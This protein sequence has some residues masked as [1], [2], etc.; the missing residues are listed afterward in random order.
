MHK[1]VVISGYCTLDHAIREGTSFTPR[2]GGAVLYAG[3]PL[4]DAGHLVTP[5]ARIG[6]DTEAMRC[7]AEAEKDGLDIS[8]FVRDPTASMARCLMIYRDDDSC[9]CALERQD[10]PL[11]AAQRALAERADLLVIA[12]GAAEAS[13]QMLDAAP[14]HALVAWV[15]KNDELCFPPPLRQR[16]ARRADVIFCSRAER[17]AIDAARLRNRRG[18]LLFETRGAAGGVV[19]ES[20]GEHG[21]AAAPVDVADATGAGD[22]FAGTALAA[23][24]AG[25]SPH[26]AATA[27]AEAAR[28]FLLRRAADE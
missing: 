3:R 27:G 10:G 7:L 6:G 19:V 4:A 8:G 15:A 14:K 26:R 12:A 18:Q 11:T 5:L 17:P 1:R 22:T 28:A 21:F 9:D 20:G 25:S 16:L 23:L 2:F 24:L 13:L